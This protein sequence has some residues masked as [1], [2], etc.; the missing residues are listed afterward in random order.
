MIFADTRISLPTR[1]LHWLVALAIVTM[2]AFGMWIAALER[3]PVKTEWI[4]IHKS[5]GVIAG[6]LIVAR[7]SWRMVEGF[8]QPDGLHTIWERRLARITH[9]SLLLVSIGLP[10]TGLL[11]SITYARPV[12]VFGFEIVPVLLSEKNERWNDYATLVH[13]FLAWAV[14]VLLI[15]HVAG[16]VRHERQRRIHRRLIQR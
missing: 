1:I 11:K 15:V 9:I 16:A 3:G 5:F 10:L 13:A 7:I 6:A 4:Q 14:L 12:A 2:V 8:P